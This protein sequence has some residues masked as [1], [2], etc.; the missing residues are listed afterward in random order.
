MQLEGG[1]D[2]FG[3]CVQ[4]AWHHGWKPEQKKLKVRTWRQELKQIPQRNAAYWLTF[5][6]CSTAQAYLSSRDLAHGASAL[7]SY[8][9]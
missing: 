6:Y 4:A 3:F 1:K 5:S 9:R 2:L 7:L 8:I